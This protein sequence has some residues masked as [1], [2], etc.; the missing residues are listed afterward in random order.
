VVAILTNL[1]SRAPAMMAEL[2][3]LWW[4]VDTNDITIRA[5]YIR[6]AANV[7]ADKLSRDR[8][9]QG[10]WTLRR[11]VFAQLDKEWGPHTMDRF[12]TANDKLVDRYNARAMGP[13]CLGVDALAQTDK[14]WRA[15]HNWCHPP[16]ALLA[17]LAGKLRASGAS[18]TVVTPTWRSE[19]WY[20]ELLGLS[21]KLR[22]EPARRD[23]F[24]RAGKVGPASWS[25]TIFSIPARR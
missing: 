8:T 16:W 19:A 1:T 5:R 13:G 10:D 4:L 24:S 17:Q 18:A 15:E 3:K 7:W 21:D 9:G 23:L 11:D 12:A 2:R 22:V 20:G 25:V 14:N 6:S